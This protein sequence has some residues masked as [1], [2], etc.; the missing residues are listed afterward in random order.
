LKDTRTDQPKLE[1]TPKKKKWKTLRT[2]EQGRG[3]DEESEESEVTPRNLELLQWSS[4]IALT[5]AWGTDKQGV[6]VGDDDGW[7]Q[8]FF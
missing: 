5:L 7:A 3:E 4:S 8:F 6:L 1:A 2:T